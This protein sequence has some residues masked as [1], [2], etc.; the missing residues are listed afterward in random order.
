M[1]KKIIAVTVCA[2]L[3]IVVIL[4]GMF[5]T[6]RRLFDAGDSHT[7]ISE[8]TEL[9]DMSTLL[10]NQESYVTT[11]DVSTIYCK[12]EILRDNI[13]LTKCR[14]PQTNPMIKHI[15][16]LRLAGQTDGKAGLRRMV[17]WGRMEET[18]RNRMENALDELYQFLISDAE[19][20]I[21]EDVSVKNMR[22]V[23]LCGMYT[24]Q[25]ISCDQMYD[26]ENAEEMV[27]TFIFE[28]DENW[29]LMP[30]AEY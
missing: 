27:I 9:M 13:D 28:G 2:I 25:G 18:E 12:P 4:A 19:I 24:C 26:Y 21:M 29:K 20:F 6:G 30:C 10:E 3:S 16:Q 17:A 7:D 15:E 11:G 8:N 22:I 23:R 5:Y 14:I 1:R